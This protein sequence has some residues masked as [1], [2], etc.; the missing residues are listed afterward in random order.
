MCEWC[1]EA[2][3]V[4]VHRWKDIG[5]E[6]DCMQNL[7]LIWIYEV[8]GWTR[9]YIAVKVLQACRVVNGD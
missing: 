1:L 3:V 5:D 9:P 8:D 6:F 7:R 2:K 4:K